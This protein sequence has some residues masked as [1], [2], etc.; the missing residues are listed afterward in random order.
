MPPDLLTPTDRGLYC[1][2]GDFYVDPWEPVRLAVVTHAH[3]DHV[4]AGCA[5]Y[6]CAASCEPLLRMRLA[7]WDEGDRVEGGVTGWVT[8]QSATSGH[9][10][11]AV[12]ARAEGPGAGTAPRIT[13]IAFGDN[14]DLGSVRISLHPA[15]HILGSAQVAIDGKVNGREQRWVVSGDYKPR[16]E[17][18]TAEVFAPVPCDTFITESTFGLPI[19]RWPDEASVF[20]EVN[21][22][23]RDNAARGR[24]SMV[25]AYALGKAQRVLSGID[26]SIGPIAVHGAVANCNAA[27]RA[28]GA[29]LPEA[30]HAMGDTINEVRGRGLVIA[31]PSALGSPWVRRFA[32]S[33]GGA[34]A[35]F[36]SGWMLVRGPR[37]RKAIDR[38]FVISDHADWDGLLATIRATGARRVG[39]T[40]GYITPMVRW[41]RESGLDAFAVPTRYTG[42]T[43]EDA[44]ALDLAA[45]DAGPTAGSNHDRAGAA[46][47]D[48]T[49]PDVNRAA[50][51]NE[52]RP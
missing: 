1:A 15:G 30:P 44:A 10:G 22:W 13:A 35:A 48:S 41:L 26:T 40:H 33:E 11:H 51:E 45:G 39:V 3:S 34:S 4:V 18:R 43:G 9:E 25:F 36:V 50:E 27:Y 2:A 29:A 37:R 17:D 24:T 42:E 52:P 31:P 32:A 46:N 16:T 49:P 19:Y 12:G 5:A 21:A 47:E 28:A 20:A 38:G 7:A 6:V 14:L 23:W 8:G